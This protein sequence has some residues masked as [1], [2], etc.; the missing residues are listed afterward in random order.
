M[1]K[2]KHNSEEGIQVQCCEADRRSTQMYDATIHWCLSFAEN[3]SS[4]SLSP[5]TSCT[6]RGMAEWHDLSRMLSENGDSFSTMYSHF[7][8][9]EE[10]KVH[11][12][13]GIPCTLLELE[14]G[15]ISARLMLEISLP[16]AE[17]KIYRDSSWNSIGKQ[18]LVEMLGTLQE[19]IL[20]GKIKDTKIV[21]LACKKV[22]SIFLL[23]RSLKFRAALATARGVGISEIPENLANLY[24]ARDIINKKEYLVFGTRTK[25]S[26]Y[27]AQGKVVDQHVCHLC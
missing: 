24:A 12:A 8:P 3:L 18:S 20:A 5:L 16:H 4:L 11:L 13:D 25:L 14:E 7:A 9:V 23:Q 17:Q 19:Q 1:A 26:L 15:R 21:S 6:L 22:N 10:K 27:T 2:R